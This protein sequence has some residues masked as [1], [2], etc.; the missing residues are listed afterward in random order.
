MKQGVIT[1]EI[2]LTMMTIS[3]WYTKPFRGS[4]WQIK[5]FEEDV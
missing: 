2:I 1:Y 3:T 5:D 4:E